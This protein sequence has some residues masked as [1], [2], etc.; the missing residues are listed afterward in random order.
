MNRDLTVAVAAGLAYVLAIVACGLFIYHLTLLGIA[1]ALAT[2]SAI[3]CSL[4][5]Q[6]WEQTFGNK[7]KRSV[8]LI[9]ALLSAA[10]HYLWCYTGETLSGLENVPQHRA[11]F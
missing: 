5:V 7:P 10:R 3:F 4:Y 2:I 1:F 6:F 8:P 9:A 11:G